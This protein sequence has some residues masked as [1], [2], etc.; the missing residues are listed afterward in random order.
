MRHFALVMFA[1]LA[2]AFTTVAGGAQAPARPA[3]VI[4]ACDKPFMFGFGSWE[5]AK[6]A[7]AARADGIHIA[8]KNAQGGAGVAG[9]NVNLAGYGDWSPAMTL[10]AG[11]QNKAT[12]LTLQL[13]DAD[14]TTHAYKFDLRKLKPGEPQQLV[15]DFGASV[16]EPQTVE[17]A[18]KTPGLDNVASI[19]VIGDWSDKPIDVVLSAI[20]L[21]PPTDALRAQRAQ[22]RELRDREAEKVRVQAEAKEKARK[23]LLDAGAPHPAD[24]PEVRSVCAVAPDVIA[25]TVQAGQHVNNQLVPYIAAAGDEVVEEKDKPRHEV[26]DG[27]VVDYFQKGLFRKVDNRRTRVGLLS[28][29]GKWVFIE[30]A[31]RGQLLDETVV[32]VPAAYTLV[33]ADD[34]NYARPRSPARVFRKGKPDGF[35]RPLPFLYT[36]SLRLPAPLKEGAAYTLRFVGVNTSRET[37]AYIHKP[38]E[39]RSIALHAIQTGYRPDDPYK[40]AY[41]SFWMGVDEDGKSGSCTPDAEGFELVDDAGKTVFTGKAELA[42]KDGGQEQICIHE[43][44]DYTK[45]TVRRLDFSA[46]R[47]PGEYRVFVP[48]VGVSGPF[49]IAANVWEKPF[50]AAMQGIL[51]QRQGIDLG[52]PACAYT[53]KRPFHP[54]DGVEFYQMT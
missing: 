10:T 46:F 3:L 20:V 14:G 27:K 11:E 21:V 50:K 51:A 23:K 36:I 6:E 25:I 12:G 1:A 32:D 37:V 26:E 47:A 54:D 45:A 31:T 9:L 13:G 18:G 33:S 22:L 7:F 48:G 34:A 42:K 40:R 2:A 8:V 52:P 44:L 38:R 39:T 4:S 29:D 24:G 30:G 28:P 5:K 43:T 19:L 35:S 15:A 17:K 49:R 53:R 41:V 16:A